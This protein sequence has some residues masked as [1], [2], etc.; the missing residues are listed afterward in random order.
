MSSNPSALRIA[1]PYARALFDYTLKK[2]VMHKVT[3]DM[4]DLISLL[5]Q[6]EDLTQYL[7]NPIIRVERK[8]EILKKILKS[9]LN[10]ETFKFLMVLIKRERISIFEDIANTY[11]QLVYQLA[12]IKTIE[13]STTCAFTHK[14]KN[15]LTQKLKKLTNAKEIKLLVTIDSSLIGGFLIK[16][17]SRVIDLSVK[18]QLKKIAS[19]LDSVLE[20]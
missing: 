15:K 3:L 7:N 19:H 17:N 5:N 8:E 10:E 20:I 13:I 12:S 11:L 4:H 18:N 14:Q 9:R 2:N 16:T 1:N 6:S